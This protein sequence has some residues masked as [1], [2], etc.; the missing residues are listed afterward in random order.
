MLKNRK[1]ENHRRVFW[2]LCPSSIVRREYFSKTEYQRPGKL[3]L[4]CAASASFRMVGWDILR[5]TVGDQLLM[6]STGELRIKH[7]IWGM[8]DWKRMSCSLRWS[9]I[10]AIIPNQTGCKTLGRWRNVKPLVAICGLFC[11][12]RPH[13]RQ[14]SLCPA[15]TKKAQKSGGKPSPK[16]GVNPF[17]EEKPVAKGLQE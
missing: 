16:A 1:F 11:M 10:W 13:Q 15:Q 17:G 12:G 5:Q 7:Q 2:R 9:W 14:K 4:G 8:Q 6:G 3:G